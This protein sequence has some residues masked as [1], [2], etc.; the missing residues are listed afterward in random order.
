[1]LK[2]RIY[3][4][5]NVSAI[6]I[7]TY[8]YAEAVAQTVMAAS[9]DY[10]QFALATVFAAPVDFVCSALPAAMIIPLVN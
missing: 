6:L 10:F 4:C 2:L 3:L 7:D 1:M 8:V 9:I 5:I